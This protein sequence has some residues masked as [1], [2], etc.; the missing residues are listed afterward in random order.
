VPSESRLTLGTA[1]R[2]NRRRSASLRERLP[3][4]RRLPARI[5]IA[6]GRTLRRGAPALVVMLVAGGLVAGALAGW[7]FVTTSSRFAIE[8]IEVRGTRTL[9]ADEIRALAPVALGDNV[10]RA[11]LG[12]IERALEVQPWIADASV[13]RRL[14]H[15]IEIEIREREAA[16]L[17]VLD[18]LYLADAGGTIFKRARVDLGEG[19]GLPVITGVSRED[20]RDTPGDASARIA[21]ALAALDAWRADPVDRPAIGE[22]RVDGHGLTL[23]TYEDALAIRLGHADGDRLLARLDTFDAA[24]S[25]LTPDERRRARAI[26]LDLD[27]RPDHV[28]VAFAR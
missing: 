6:C 16:A 19:E 9:T 17:V 11:D 4:V 2:N 3:E 24:W 26:H 22:V 7:R 5:V 15:T 18:G 14:P 25:A 12:R 10:F 28:T 1:R 21:A 8:A 23:F 13:S 20:Y 27:T